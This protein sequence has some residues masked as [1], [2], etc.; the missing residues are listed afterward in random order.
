[1]AEAARPRRNAM[2]ELLE[3]SSFS[4]S[5]NRFAPTPALDGTVAGAL[6]RR[7]SLCIVAAIGLAVGSALGLAGTFVS[8]DSWRQELWAIDGVALV[9][10]LTLFEGA[11]VA[12]FD[13][14]Y[15]VRA[16]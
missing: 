2:G 4:A 10:R 1:V 14:R 9:S 11:T 6:G 5:R 13:G 12:A 16:A 7:T 8:H 15:G 3:A